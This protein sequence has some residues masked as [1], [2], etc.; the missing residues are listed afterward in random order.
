M[1][2]FTCFPSLSSFTNGEPH[3]RQVT[4]NTIQTKVI[5]TFYAKLTHIKACLCLIKNGLLCDITCTW[6]YCI[7]RGLW[8]GHLGGRWAY[9]DRPLLGALKHRLRFSASGQQRPH[10]SR[11]SSAAC[12]PN[13]HACP[14]EHREQAGAPEVTHTPQTRY[15][16]NNTP[17]RTFS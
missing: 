8:C 17:A 7:M 3:N 12:L 10:A 4:D 14:A 11:I 16:L 6:Q 1:D 2:T 9:A 13:Y 15:L 5:V